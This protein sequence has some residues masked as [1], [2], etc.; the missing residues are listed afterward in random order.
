MLEYVVKIIVEVDF[1]EFVDGAA[2]R[3]SSDSDSSSSATKFTVS[4]PQTFK[5]AFRAPL[6]LLA[7]QTSNI[8]HFEHCCISAI[9]QAVFTVAWQLVHSL[10]AG[11]AVRDIEFLEI[12]CK[13][14]K[15]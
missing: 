2:A 1:E 3:A 10:N 5:C 9:L 7:S 6:Q 12:R 4:T 14:E 8:S 13:S 11:L 15:G